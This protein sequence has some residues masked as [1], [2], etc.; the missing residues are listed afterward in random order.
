MNVMQKL[1]ITTNHVKALTYF[2]SIFK[3]G[4]IA[5]VYMG[6]M[7]MEIICKKLLTG[8]EPESHLVGLKHEWIKIVKMSYCRYRADV[9]GNLVFHYRLRNKHCHHLSTKSSI[10]VRQNLIILPVISFL[11]IPWVSESHDLNNT[12]TST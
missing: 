1:F 10:P 11:K 8:M 4:N 2:T 5:A 7:M 12:C 9:L 6:I 3:N